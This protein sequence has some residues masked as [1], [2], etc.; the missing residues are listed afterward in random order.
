[1][2][3]LRVPVRSQRD[4]D[5][6]VSPSDLGLAP[7]APAGLPRERREER[8]IGG[9]VGRRRVGLRSTG[10]CAHHI[11]KNLD[12][13]ERANAR[14]I[15][16]RHQRPDGGD[17]RQGRDRS[18]SRVGGFPARTDLVACQGASLAI[19]SAIADLRGNRA[20]EVPAGPTSGARSVTDP[21]SRCLCLGCR[22][23]RTSPQRHAVMVAAGSASVDRKTGDA[24]RS[25]GAWPVT[26]SAP[27][28]W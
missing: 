28:R 9:R 7:Q 20:T 17:A 2:P 10:A 3:R 14:S 4:D 6:I 16:I 27:V 5:A 26:P 12:E 13:F 15:V 21:A 19:Q 22:A 8:A 25:F 23:M 11:R 1:M 24:P 18:S